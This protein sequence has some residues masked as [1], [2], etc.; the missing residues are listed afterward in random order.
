[1][2]RSRHQNQ[3]ILS[4]PRIQCKP[5]CSQCQARHRRGPGK[6]I[7][8]EG[9]LQYMDDHQKGQEDS[10]QHQYHAEGEEEARGIHGELYQLTVTFYYE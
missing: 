7:Q 3:L 9:R 4:P 6:E 8:K 2:L 5:N 10:Q 1:M